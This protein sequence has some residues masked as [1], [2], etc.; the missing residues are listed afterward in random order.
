MC[1]M[2][3]QILVLQTQIEPGSPE[4]EAQSLNHWTTKEFP[5]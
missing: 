4:L 1:C 5:L 3:V 2:V